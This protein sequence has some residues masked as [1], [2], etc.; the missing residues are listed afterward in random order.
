MVPTKHKC[1]L[2]KNTIKGKAI[3]RLGTAFASNDMSSIYRGGNMMSFFNTAGGWSV[4]R[5][6]LSYA[7]FAAG[8]AYFGEQNAEGYASGTF[9]VDA[10]TGQ[11]YIRDIPNTEWV[12]AREVVNFGSP[13]QNADYVSRAYGAIAQVDQ[14]QTQRCPT[15]LDPSTLHKN[16]LGLSYPGGNNPLSYNKQYNYSYVGSAEKLK[17]L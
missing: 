12:N 1:S 4:G 14:Q 9:R 15:C 11:A 16:L 5:G 10:R 3:M 2:V 8:D 6:S 13:Y 17:I 7:S